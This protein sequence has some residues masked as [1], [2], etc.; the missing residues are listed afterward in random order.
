[1]AW[2]S[3]QED[4]PQRKQSP[5]LGESWASWRPSGS[6]IAGADVSP[7]GAL[8]ALLDCGINADDVL[9]T[10]EIDDFEDA[11][12]DTLLGESC[13]LHGDRELRVE[14]EGERDGF[15]AI[16]CSDG[17]DDDDRLD[18][19]D[20]RR[21]WDILAGVDL[22]GLAIRRASGPSS[23]R[24]C[25]CASWRR[26]LVGDRCDCRPAVRR[27]LLLCQRQDLFR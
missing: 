16:M 9:I 10:A 26:T 4:G 27:H 8:A 2:I 5:M 11:A 14:E 7:V 17:A 19:E 25:R 23:S 3:A 22:E 21:D 12:R 24:S 15:E 18:E 20:G 13:E 1:M 6:S